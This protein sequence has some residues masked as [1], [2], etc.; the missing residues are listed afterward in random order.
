MWIV[1]IFHKL[2]TRRWWSLWCVTIFYCPSVDLSSLHFDW[3]WTLVIGCVQSRCWFKISGWVQLCRMKGF[4]FS[5]FCLKSSQII[6]KSVKLLGFA[7]PTKLTIA[8]TYM[9]IH[10]SCWRLVLI[11]GTRIWR[12]EASFILQGVK[13]GIHNLIMWPNDELSLLV[14]SVDDLEE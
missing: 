9:W 7:W 6:S 1:F 2:A 11:D 13:D 5:L 14:S 12:V 3:N 10:V 4:H 8:A